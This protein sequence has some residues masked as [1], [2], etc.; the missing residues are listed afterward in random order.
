MSGA[1]V[2]DVEAM[3]GVGTS[4][5]GRGFSR[6]WRMCRRELELIFCVIGLY[7]SYLSYGILQEKIFK[8]DY[9]D[10][11]FKSAM[12]MV[13]CQCAVGSVT[14]KAIV[15]FVSTETGVN[16]S[17]ADVPQYKFSLCAF[18]VLSSMVLSNAAIQFI[19][20][21]LQVLAKSCKMIP[22]M[23]IGKLILRRV[24]T[25]KDYAR[26][27]LL[28]AGVVLFSNASVKL[29]NTD[30]D[31]LWSHGALGLSLVVAALCFDGVGG[32]YAERTCKEYG[33]TSHEL[34]L[35][36]NLWSVPILIAG[37]ESNINQEEIILEGE[38][39][40]P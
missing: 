1:A 24:Y 13:L 29:S 8:T 27:F 4:A 33:T 11:K 10:E 15:A 3:H 12:F 39:S 2:L 18:A 38:R 5:E 25:I 30:V 20:Y 22:V 32:P 16:S 19:S 35:Y 40:A 31:A 9:G 14:G 37:E 23:F 28:T 7:L 26:V 36:Q 6:F 17:K 34:M 21:P